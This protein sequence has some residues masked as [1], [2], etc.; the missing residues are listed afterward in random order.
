MRYILIALCLMLS[1]VGNSTAQTSEPLH[2]PAEPHAVHRLVWSPDGTQLLRWGLFEFSVPIFDATTGDVLHQ[3]PDGDQ[4]I[5]T[6]D[7]YIIGYTTMTNGETGFQIRNG[8]NYE[9]INEINTRQGNFQPDGNI[10]I[11]YANAVWNIE[12]WLTGE[13]IGPMS[14]NTPHWSADG[15]RFLVINAD[16]ETPHAVVLDATGRSI[17]PAITLEDADLQP[18]MKPDGMAALLYFRAEN[19][20]QVWDFEAGTLISLQGAEGTGNAGCGRAHRFVAWQPNTNH[21]LLPYDETKGR[22]YDAGTGDV[23]LEI[24]LPD[25]TIRYALFNHR[26][27]QLLLVGD[28]APRVHILDAD[29]GAT[30]QRVNTVAPVADQYITWSPDDRYVTT[31]VSGAEIAVWEVATG[32]ERTRVPHASGVVACNLS[33][34]D[35]V[36]SPDSRRIATAINGEPLQ[37]GAVLSVGD[38]ARVDINAD[39]RL[40]VYAD[41]ADH[42]A[43]IAELAHGSTVDLLERRQDGIES[44]WRIRT[45]A[46][47]DGW[48]M[49]GLHNLIPVAADYGIYITTL[50]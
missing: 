7:N 18:I 10:A 1:I 35:P 41:L 25:D 8:D 9:L 28:H 11:T 5:W 17:T 16:H 42:S 29:T 49:Q 23:K 3:L 47:D 15:S 12:N 40:P 46:G 21:I 48:V 26:G 20:H 19:V 43:I 37:Y 24:A 32:Q 22:I 38:R 44:W 36:W 2:I 27:D 30:L 31:M 33:T 4:H 45:S 13:W 50:P 39:D 6:A 34:F 14:D